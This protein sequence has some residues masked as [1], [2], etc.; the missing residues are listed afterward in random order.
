MASKYYSVHEVETRTG[1]NARTIRHWIRRRLLSPPRGRGRGAYYTET[2]V[3]RVLAIRHLRA[4]GVSL[5]AIRAQLTG[6]NEEQL[7][8]IVP[9]P[10]KSAAGGPPAP[11]PEPK[12]PAILRETVT[13]MDG[14]VLL[15]RADVPPLRRLANDIYAHYGQARPA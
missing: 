1:V 15:V 8:A 13:S 7:R 4:T 3:L 5:D 2:Q 14:L 9:P 11:P 12:Y 6:L 10:P